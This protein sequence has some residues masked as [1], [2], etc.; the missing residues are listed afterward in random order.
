MWPTDWWNVSF[1]SMASKIMIKT[2]TNF[3]TQTNNVG[4][5]N[6]DKREDLSQFKWIFVK[7]FY[8]VSRFTFKLYICTVFATL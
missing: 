2:L 8:N 4:P 3:K 6:P 7:I 5:K 1:R